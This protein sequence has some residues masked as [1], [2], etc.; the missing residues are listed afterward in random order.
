VRARNLG[1]LALVVLGLGL[2]PALQAAPDHPGDYP[3]GPKDLLEVRVLEVPELNVE[4]RVSDAGTIELPLLG[5]FPVSGLTASEAR[6]H[7]ETLLTSKYVNR[8]TVSIT[9]REYANKPVSILG[10]VKIPGS[11]RISGRWTLI[12]AISAAGG[13]SE[14]AGKKIFVLREG[15]GGKPETIEVGRDELFRGASDR[16][17]IPLFPG[18]VVNVPARTTVTVYC[19]GEVKQ[20]GAVSFDSDDRLTLLAAIAKAGG[21]TNRASNTIRIR[22]RGPDGH[23]VDTIVHF[24]RVL[25]GK[26]PDPTLAADDVIIV[27][28]SFF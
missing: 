13:L 2:G 8:A 25:S 15:N 24:K 4:R 17:N 9:I 7:L 19:L 16:W 18:D 21:L 14:S 28:E 5:E 22:R 12:Q 23:D 20:P 1:L 6:E 27:T 26:D 3:I 10:A 11:L